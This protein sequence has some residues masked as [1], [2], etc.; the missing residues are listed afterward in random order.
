MPVD[1]RESIDVLLQEKRVFPPP[2][3]LQEKAHIK[4]AEEYERLYRES[5]EDPDGFWGRMG[6]IL[7][8]SKKW[9]KGSEWDF[10]KP[11][12]KWYLNG[13]LNA[14]YNC[15]DRHLSTWKRNKAAIIWEGDDGTTKTYTYQQLSR[16]VNR[17]ANVLKKSGVTKGDRVT[18]YLPMIPELAISVLACARIGA[19]H[20]VVF[21]GFSPSSLRDRILDS[22]SRLVVTSDQ[23]VRGGKPIPMKENCDAALAEC[24]GIE[25]VIV[26][27]RTGNPVPFVED[28][29]SWW[30]DEMDAPGIT[31]ICPPEEMDSEDALFIL[32][33]SGSTDKPKRGP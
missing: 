31:G 21:G 12:I 19:I 1:K 18:I 11:R 16:E 28:R 17:F 25:K 15:L 9:D 13:K 7:D 27:K 2:A 29:D 22:D 32:Y 30:H 8:W 24:P 23:G 6:G 3:E 20:S 10:H 26:V 33:T 4:G 14:S 5:V